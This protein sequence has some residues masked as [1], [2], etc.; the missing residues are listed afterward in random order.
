MASTPCRSTSSTASCS[1]VPR[2]TTGPLQHLGW[3]SGSSRVRVTGA[4]TGAPVG[5]RRTGDG[6]E[7]D[8]WAYD[9]SPS[10]R[11]GWSDPVR[12]T[13]GCP[14]DGVTP[15]EIPCIFAGVCRSPPEPRA[16]GQAADTKG[17]QGAA[18][19]AA[20]DHHRDR[21]GA[22]LRLDRP[23]LMSF[24]MPTGLQR[25]LRWTLVYLRLTA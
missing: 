18:A 19:T 8:A 9:G 7:A 23:R 25:E 6:A 3:A 2:P 12:W 16:T 14:P 5:E 21:Q 17:L 11:H 10:M 22:L 20:P 15:A 13:P 4:D 24:R 1:V